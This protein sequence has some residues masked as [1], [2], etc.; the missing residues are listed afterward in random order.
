MKNEIIYGMKSAYRDRFR[1]QAFRFGSGEKALAVVGSMRG[2]EIQQQYVC[3][4]LVRRLIEIEKAGLMMPGIEILVIPS[5]NPYSMNL[6]KRFWTMDGTDINRMFPGYE[7]GETT[8]RIASAVFKTI[9]GYKYGIQMA[10]FYMPGDFIPHVRMI[11]SGYENT[12]AAALFGLPYICIR[13]PL[14]FD[15]TLLNYN[16]QIWQTNAFSIYAGQTNLVEHAT[17]AET[18]EALIRF[19]KKTKMIR[20]VRVN[21]GYNSVLFDENSLVTVKSDY[22]GILYRYRKPNENVEKG[23]LLARIINPYDGSVVCDVLSPVDG[24]IFF[25]ANKPLTMEGT[26]LFRLIKD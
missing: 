25:A 12:E 23:S 7:S 16:W 3:S 9:Q 19:M 26:L 18:L 11:S 21:P 10:S 24:I 5:V 20:G 22:G 15:T 2:D 13:Q 14:P 6:E 1:I 8:Q 4:Q 17:S